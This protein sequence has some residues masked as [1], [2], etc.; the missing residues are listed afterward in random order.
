MITEKFYDRTFVSS[1]YT[2]LVYFTSGSIPYTESFV[3]YVNGV[4]AKTEEPCIVFGI[5]KRYFIAGK[6]KQEE[7]FWCHP[8]S[9]KHKL[10]NLLSTLG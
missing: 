5:N 6:E 3:R 2:G 8:A 7:E 9:I 10:E 1:D 4:G